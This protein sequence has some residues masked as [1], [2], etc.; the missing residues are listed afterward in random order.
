MWEMNLRMRKFENGKSNVG[1][2]S[3]VKMWEMNL[4]MRRCGL[5]SEWFCN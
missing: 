2:V 5:K 1:S 3:N 4:K